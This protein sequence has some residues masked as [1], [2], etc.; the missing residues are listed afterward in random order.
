MQEKGYDAMSDEL[1]EILENTEYEIVHNADKQQAVIQSMLDNVVSMYSSAYGKIN[2]IIHNT[3]WVG[4]TDFNT[5]QSNLSNQ[6]GASNQVSNATQHQSNVSSTGTAQS[7]VT[8]PINNNDSFNQKFEQEIIQD[9]NTTNRPVAELKLSAK[10]VTLE[11]GKSTS[12]SVQI[13]PT[14]A[15]N[16]T[17]EWKSSNVKIATV[18]SG[19]IK[20]VKP[21][22]C[23]IT[24]STTDGSGISA[25]V[26]VTVT[27][28]PDPPKPLPKPSSSSNSNGSGDGVPRIGDAVTFAS[29]RY[30]YDSQG[31]NPSGNKYQGQTVYIT[32]INTRSWA[33]KPY[34]ISR[35]TSL[36][37]GDLGWVTLDQLRG[38]NKGTKR[39]PKDGLAIFDETAGGK[40]DPGS[41]VIVTKYGTLK[42]FN[43]GDRVFAN[44]QVQRLWDISNGENPFDYV[45][46][47][48]PPVYIPNVVPT[49][50]TQNMELHI[51]KL[52][53]IEG[54]TITKDSIPDIE[55]AIKSN[56]PMIKKEVSNLMYR[57]ARMSGV[58]KVR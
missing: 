30:Y 10:S 36:G 9:P 35:G 48:T 26:G 12:I 38:Y 51:D 21:G 49:H 33:N 20:A 37:N 23:Q 58:R 56:I 14:D 7:T 32:N 39:V 11:E 16:K 46:P 25:S 43:A 31:V 13:R 47:T 19:K 50:N 52:L 8:S 34:H 2:E 29:G 28:K 3:G 15:K 1:H 45:R 54:G 41:E 57:D 22:S 40:S 5:N 4:S 44:E 24:A 42:Q 53:T 17:L 27:K 55:K 6:A 18:S